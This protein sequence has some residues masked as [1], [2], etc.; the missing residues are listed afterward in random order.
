VDQLRK[1]FAFITPG[2]FAKLDFA[3]RD[4]Y[5][6]DALIELS[7]RLAAVRRYPP[8]EIFTEA[9]ERCAAPWNTASMLFPSGSRTKQA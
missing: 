1:K 8:K 4:R 6:R 7:R 9:A 5:L 3:Q 2:E